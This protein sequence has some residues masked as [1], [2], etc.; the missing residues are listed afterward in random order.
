[1]LNIKKTLTKILH[2]IP[3]SKKIRQTATFSSGKST[4]TLNYTLPTGANII[5]VSLATRPNADWITA[6]IN[7]Y[8]NTACVIS[9]DNTYSGSLS[10]TVELDILYTL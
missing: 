5:S 7:A 8:G 6:D 9:Y 4:L 2:S 3:Q 10:G 1:M